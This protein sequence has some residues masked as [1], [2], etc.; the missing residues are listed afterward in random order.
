MNNFGSNA[1]TASLKKKAN[2]RSTVTN[3]PKSNVNKLMAKSMV[4]K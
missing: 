1:S 2:S 4:E 3:Y